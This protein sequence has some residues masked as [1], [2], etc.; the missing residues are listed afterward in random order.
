MNQWAFVI[1]VAVA[2]ISGYSLGYQVE[3]GRNAK[4]VLAAQHETFK[5]AEAA[6]RQEEARLAAERE[7]NAIALQ[8]EDAANA[9]TNAGRVCLGSDSVLR[10]N[11]R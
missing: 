10:L 2:G 1:C 5:A 6:S 11:Q 9:D 3:A 4:S 7:R 8:L